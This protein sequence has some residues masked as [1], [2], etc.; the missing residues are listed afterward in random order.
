M[1]NFFKKRHS[2]IIKHFNEIGVNKLY[3]FKDLII[4]TKKLGG[5]VIICGNGG[6]SATAS[7]FSVDLS[8]NAKIKSIN[9]NESDMITCF[10]NDFGYKNWLKK[11]LEIYSDPKDLL[12]LLSC[13]GNSMNL[14]NANLFAKKSGLKVVTLTGCKKKNKLNN[15][16][17]DLNIWINSSKYNVI[18]IIHHAI[19]LNLIDSIIEDKNF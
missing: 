19:L 1:K 9:F 16:R 8:L 17:N 18:E 4:K 13:S 7:H 10:A 12:I 6:S 14:V 5:K 3:Q 2:E 11:A 15:S